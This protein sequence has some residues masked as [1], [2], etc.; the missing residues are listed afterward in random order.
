MSS[1]VGEALDGQ[2]SWSLRAKA[3]YVLGILMLFD[4]WDGV[5]IAYVLPLLIG[6]WQ[7]S[8]LQSGWLISAGYGM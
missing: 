5:V 7:L 8:A 6:Q 3:P 1:W 2:G 4:S